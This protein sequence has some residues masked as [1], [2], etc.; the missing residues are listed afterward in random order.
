MDLQK[1]RAELKKSQIWLEKIKNESK[2]TRN[3]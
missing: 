3:L 1:I 2:I